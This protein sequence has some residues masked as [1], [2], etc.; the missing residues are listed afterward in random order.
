MPSPFNVR[1]LRTKA[2]IAEVARSLAAD[3]QQEPITV[4]PGTG[5][6]TKPNRAWSLAA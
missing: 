1:S 2:R 4:Y 3:G 5:A 6:E